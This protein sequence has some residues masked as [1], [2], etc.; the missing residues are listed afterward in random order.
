MANKPN[1]VT[2]HKDLTS[3]AFAVMQD[4]KKIMDL[5]NLLAPVVPTGVTNGGYNIFE[6][7]SAFKQ[8]ADARRAVGGHA[9]KIGLLSDN[10]TFSA[11]P[12][13]LRTSIDN[14]ERTKA[15]EGINLLMQA[16]TRFLTIDCLNS[17]LG[18]V[19]TKIKAAVSALAGKGNWLS[20]DVDPIAEIN[21][22]IKAV[23][24]ASGIVPNNVVIDFGAW[25]VLSQHPKVIARMPGAETSAL[26]QTRLA[27]M[28][29]NPGAKVTIVESAIL[30]GGGLGNSSASMVS[31][32]GGSVLVFFNSE[33]AT[34][35]DPSFCKTFAVGPSLFTEV[36]SYLELPHFEWF[37]NDWTSDTKVVSSVLCKR[38]DVTG[39]ND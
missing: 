24:K 22:A 23:F 1:N 3:Y 21:A 27:S 17:H 20:A 28:L 34:P 12:F 33:M 16:K 32:M 6:K 14:H 15:G 9:T 19:V 18:N 4:A 11:E 37:E 13:G 31:A 7:T 38:I 35:Y 10:A 26:N 5:T 30:T 36:Y 2:V 39:A 29:V 8:Y 25:C